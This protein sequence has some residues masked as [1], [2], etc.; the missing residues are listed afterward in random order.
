MWSAGAIADPITILNTQDVFGDGLWNKLENYYYQT[1]FNKLGDINKKLASLDDFQIGIQEGRVLLQQDPQHLMLADHFGLT[2]SANIPVG[3][4]LNFG[5]DVG[6]YLLR[7]R[8]VPNPTSAASQ[9]PLG[10]DLSDWNPKSKLADTTTFGQN[11]NPWIDAV[12][13]D[14]K[15]GNMATAASMFPNVSA[16]SQSPTPEQQ[17][18]DLLA[19]LK[20]PFEMPWTSKRVL[21]GTKFKLG[22]LASFIASGGIFARVGGIGWGDLTAP[23]AGL[24]LNGQF[25][26]GIFKIDPTTCY[27]RIDTMRQEGLQYEGFQAHFQIQILN[28]AVFGQNINESIKFSPFSISGASFNSQL[29]ARTY[30]LDFSQPQV[31]AAYDAAVHGNLTVLDDL[32]AVAGS[33]AEV[34]SGRYDNGDYTQSQFN[35]KFG[36]ITFENSYS[37]S[38]IEEKFFDE[39]G[40]F[41]YFT[42]NATRASYTDINLLLWKVRQTKTASISTQAYSAA[43]EGPYPPRMSWTLDEVNFDATSEDRA[44]VT[45]FINSLKPNM[46]KLATGGA[47]TSQ[48]HAAFQIQVHPEGIM[49]FEKHTPDDVWKAAGKILFK[50]ATVWKDSATRQEWL[51]ANETDGEDPTNDNPALDSYYQVEHWAQAFV[52]PPMT[53]DFKSWFNDLLVWQRTSGWDVL[54]VQL[55]LALVS[56]ENRY[57]QL[58]LDTPDGSDTISYTD[59]TQDTTAYPDD[60]EYLFIPP[61]PF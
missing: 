9:P 8:Q 20:L 32:A 1:L 23:W 7:I 14:V 31:A 54:G 5:G 16:N 46:P 3:S 58:D 6:A 50:D 15:A 29:F 24:F 49:D 51:N 61:I 21:D 38:N 52:K 35:I 19:G 56:R 34:I 22:D 13:A 40:N 48:Y 4:L 57:L 12:A 10:N 47:K 26:F 11:I 33:G 43:P 59:G 30:K 36:P 25:R 42:A 53:A 41:D 37:S 55:F 45:E 28:G 18:L 17:Y 2:L 27:L 44:S 60:W 39:R